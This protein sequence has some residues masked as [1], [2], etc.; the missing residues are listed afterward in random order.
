MR[1]AATAIGTIAVLLLFGAHV[2]ADPKSD[3][4]ELMNG[5]L[6]FG[7]QML[8]KYGSFSPYGAALQP[9][10]KKVTLGGYPGSE[11]WENKD[12]LALLQAGCRK[13]AL[14]GEYK[15]TA[16]FYDVRVTAP[17][18]DVK[19]DAI[20]VAL[21]HR[22]G[23]SVIVYF[24]YTITEGAVEIGDLFSVL[25]KNRIFVPDPADSKL[26]RP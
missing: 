22:D 7:R 12:T 11:S 5:L 15:A 3:V 19:V 8:E 1:V 14:K 24:P 18:A 2:H 13:G 23:Y 26:E 20:A 6:P 4:E 17:G 25:G 16:I 10:G 21:D 9:D